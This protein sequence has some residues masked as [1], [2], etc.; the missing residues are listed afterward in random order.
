[1]PLKNMPSSG[2]WFHC[3]QATSQALQPMQTVVSVKK[4][5]AAFLLKLRHI[6]HREP[7]HPAGVVRRHAAGDVFVRE[8]IEVKPQFAFELTVQAAAAK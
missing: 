7:G 5:I 3:L 8:L 4:P 6:S 2:N 1:M